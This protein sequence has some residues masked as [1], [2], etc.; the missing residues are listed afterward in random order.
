MLTNCATNFMPGAVTFLDSIQS[1]MQKQRISVDTMRPEQRL[2]VIEQS[3]NCLY[4]YDAQIIGDVANRILQSDL[5]NDPDAQALMYAFYKHAQDP[6]FISIVLQYLATQN[7][8]S[9]NGV[10][11]AVLVKVLAKYYEEHA[12]KEKDKKKDDATVPS[13]PEIKHIQA[14]VETLLGAMADQIVVSCGNMTHDSALAVAACLAMNNDQTIIEIIRS[15]LPIKA[16]IFSDVLGNPGGIVQGAL[17]LKKSDIHTKLTANQTEFLNSLK[18][19]LYKMLDEK[20]EGNL[21]L[22]NYLV[23][24]YGSV[25]PDLSPYYIQL[26]DCGTGYPNLITVAKQ[27]SN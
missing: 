17:R 22:Y 25:K 15:D 19:W 26:K 4:S 21:Q 8:P 16:S 9:L 14:A 6:A 13:Y 7:K 18:Q 12:P 27:I 3:R 10:V 11:G 2:S 23:S 5:D 24:V 20:P 1:Y